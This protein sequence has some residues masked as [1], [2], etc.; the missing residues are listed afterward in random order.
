MLKILLQILQFS[1]AYSQ[2]LAHSMN[3]LGDK[4]TWVFIPAHPHTSYVS[5]HKIL[6]PFL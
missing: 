2:A 4:M 6:N 3:G 5:L 1:H